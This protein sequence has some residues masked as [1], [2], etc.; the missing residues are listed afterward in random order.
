VAALH[1]YFH[2]WLVV[3]GSHPPRHAVWLLVLGILCLLL[4]L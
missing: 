4:A 3:R 1:H 2:G